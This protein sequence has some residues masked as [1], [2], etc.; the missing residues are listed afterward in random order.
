MNTPRFPRVGLVPDRLPVQTPQFVPNL[1]A[2]FPAASP[3]K[4]GSGGIQAP[5]MG[6]PAAP[7]AEPV[8]D[9]H[10]YANVSDLGTQLAQNVSTQILETPA[11][12]RNYLMI[13]NNSTLSNIYIGFGTQASTASTLRLEPGQIAMFDVVVPQNDIYAFADNADGFVAFSFSNI[14]V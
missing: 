10:H 2:N 4:P 1:P 9:A 5:S 13:R 14:V 12:R 6:V 3:I 11:G 7:M 8:Y